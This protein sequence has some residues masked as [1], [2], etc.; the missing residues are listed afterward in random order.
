MLQ[1]ER[2]TYPRFQRK[3]LSKGNL[4]IEAT[5][6]NTKVS[7]ADTKGN[8]VMWATSGALGFKSAKKSTPYAAAKVSE[9]IADKAIAI[10]VKNVDITVKGVG[11][12]RESAIRSFVNK[13]FVVD[14]IS[15]KTPVPHNGPRKKKPRRV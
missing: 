12:G 13:G 1:K 6:N 7:F 14:S 3:K 5:N 9:L 10:G 2:E 8:I 11:S 4:T 15:D